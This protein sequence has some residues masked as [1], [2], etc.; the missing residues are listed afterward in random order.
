MAGTKRIADLALI[1]R[2]G[3]AG[4]R[5]YFSR[6]VPPVARPS[7]DAV[8]VGGAGPAER[9]AIRF[10]HDPELVFH[11]SD[12]RWVK[13]ADEAAGRPFTRIRTT[14]LG[15]FGVV[16]PLPVT[17]TEDVLAAELSE[18]PGLREFYDVFHH[19]IL[20]LF[21]RAWQKHRL[22]AGHRADAQDPFTARALAFVGADPGA[23]GPSREIP[24]L[25]RLGLAPLFSRRTRTARDLRVVLGRTLPGYPIDVECFVLRSTELLPDQ[26]VTLGVRNTTLGRDMAFGRRVADRSGRFRVILGPLSQEQAEAVAPGGPRHAAL[27]AVLD[28]FSGGVLE[29]EVEVRMAP[30]QVPRFRLSDGRAGRLGRT[31]RLG[32]PDPAAL[33]SRFVISASP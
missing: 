27:A 21:F 5:F 19:R 6:A 1:E 24:P 18:Q 30:D 16:S 31:T 8:P 20:G 13:P 15:L 3:R 22:H 14:F 7:P 17:M 10:E 9:E 29:A 2:L 33:R 4:G 11:T 25:A 32:T 28:H 23:P 12:V 26:R